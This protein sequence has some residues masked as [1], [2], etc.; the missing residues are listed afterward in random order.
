MG[1]PVNE[2]SQEY[3]RRIRREVPARV[4][5]DGPVHENVLTGDDLDV[6]RLPIIHHFPIDV[7]PYI[8]AGLVFC[9]DPWND[10]VNTFGFHRIQYKGQ[11]DRL[12]I[13]LHSRRRVW[14][15]QRRAEEE[16]RPLEVAVVLGTHP[17]LALAS[18]S[19][20]GPDRGKLETAG[21]LLDEPVDV[22]RA[23]TVDVLVPA[24]A[25]MVIEGE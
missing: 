19:L 9:R 12:G 20:V 14:E 23:R 13:S 24:Q 2:V 10:E 11:R 21:A 22:V 8:T 3:A 25:E 16:G 5:D 1:V 6:G 18:L 4:V 17:L 7:A 15:Y